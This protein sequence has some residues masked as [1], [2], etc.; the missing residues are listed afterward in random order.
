MVDMSPRSFIP[1]SLGI[2]VVFVGGAWLYLSATEKSTLHPSPVGRLDVLDDPGFVHLAERTLPA[3][4]ELR[5]QA[6]PPDA[7]TPAQSRSTKLTPRP[8]GPA[9]GQI[10]DQVARRLDEASVELR[11]DADASF[12]SLYSKG[13]LAAREG[14]FNTAIEHFDDA[15]KR[16]P[17]GHAALAAKADVLV[18]QG[19][20][21][22]ARDAYEQVL[23]ANANDPEVRYNYAVV[24]YRLSDFQESAH[25]LRQV[26]RRNPGHANA[27][28]NLASLAQRE[29]RIDEARASWE[30]FTRLR[31]NV[32]SAWFNL[33]VTYVDFDL[34][35]EAACAFEAVT[36]ITPDDAD[37]FLNLGIARAVAGD[38]RAALDALRIANELSPCDETLLRYLATLHDILADQG[39]PDAPRHRQIA[40]TLQEQVDSQAVAP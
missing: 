39:S 2:F 3:K 37:A 6:A 30:A 13:A 5:M 15:L 17:T 8:R 20:F 38:Y 1:V 23:K 4:R 9:L 7:R 26:I 27:H 19:R 10:I 36:T 11:H 34:P 28:Y 40:A 21:L 14:D 22:E 24:L 32:A 33:G 31:P 29:G 12:V 16:N 35:L 18:A 25:Q